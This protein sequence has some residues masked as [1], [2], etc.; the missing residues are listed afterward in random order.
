MSR[1]ITLKDK[2][3]VEHLMSVKKVAEEINEIVKDW[4]KKDRYVGKLNL[5]MERYKEKIRS[6]VADNVGE[7][8]EFEIVGS[9]KEEN[10]EAV[11]EIFD[12]IE[13]YKE[14]LRKQKDDNSKKKDSEKPKS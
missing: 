14:Q 12:Q 8:G 5:K 13:I 6:I 9:T 1:K 7:I 3:L 11:I 10:G 2:K 4:E